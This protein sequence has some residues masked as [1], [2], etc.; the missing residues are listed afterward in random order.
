MGVYHSF[1]SIYDQ[2]FDPAMYDHW[3]TFSQQRVHLERPAVLDL[4]GGAG[5]FAS[6][7]AQRGWQMTDLDQSEEMLALASEHA[8]AANVKVTLVEGDMTELTGLPTY[9]V[10]TCYADSLNYLPTPAQVS[11]TLKEVAAHLSTSGVFLF[12][13][14]TPYQTD[15]VYPGYMYNDETDDQQAALMWRSYADDDVDH[16]VVHDLV[17][18]HRNSNGSY[19]RQ[20]ELHFERA[21]PLPWWQQQLQAAGFKNVK[22]TADFGRHQPTAT[23]TRWFFECHR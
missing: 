11:Q 23:T 18:F 2:L 12:D 13:V 3:A 7:M 6:L 19:D 21:Y 5:R 14:I 22:V 1:A 16:G 9:D 10:V 4:A 15:V 20:A 8:V 17:I